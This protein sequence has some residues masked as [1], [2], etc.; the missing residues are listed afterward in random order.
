[1]FLCVLGVVKHINYKLLVFPHFWR[2]CIAKKYFLSKGEYKVRLVVIDAQ[3]GGL[4]KA[5]IERIKKV[6]PGTKVLAVGTNAVATAALLKAG[7]D[8]AATGENAVC[9]NCGK[10]DI[11]MG[12]TGIMCANAMMGEISPKMARAVA[13]SEAVKL[14]IPLN[15]CK[16]RICGLKDLSIPEKIEQAVQELKEMLAEC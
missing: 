5:L 9:Y 8:A 15:R 10:A 6:C 2:G 1:M 4:G 11:I 3:G 14:L 16:L 7:A 13:E 12:G